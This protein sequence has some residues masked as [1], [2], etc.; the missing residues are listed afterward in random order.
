MPA[1]LLGFPWAASNFLFNSGSSARFLTALES[2]SNSSLIVAD[3]AVSSRVRTGRGGLEVWIVN[4]LLRE[5]VVLLVTRDG[6]E[7]AEP[8]LGWYATDL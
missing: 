5:P 2:F 4:D 1:A 6:G 7:D 8:A 3:A